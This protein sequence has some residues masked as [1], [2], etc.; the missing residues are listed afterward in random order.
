MY[1][2]DLDRV[3]ACRILG[4][5]ERAPRIMYCRGYN[6]YYDRLVVLVP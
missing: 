2:T 4:I 5:Q 1:D 3:H 6:Y